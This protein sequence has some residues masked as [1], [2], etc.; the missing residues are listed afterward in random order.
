MPTVD[1][2]AIEDL[3]GFAGW[4]CPVA[5]DLVGSDM[6]C[7]DGAILKNT[8]RLRQLLQFMAS[9]GSFETRRVGRRSMPIC[10]LDMAASGDCRTW[11]VMKVLR[12]GTEGQDAS[13]ALVTQTARRSV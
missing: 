9:R 8:F 7:N 3:T 6:L 12:V 11:V 2:R 13:L 5:F 10:G 1:T 4:P